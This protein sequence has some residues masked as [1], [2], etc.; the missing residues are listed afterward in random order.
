MK[1]KLLIASGI[2]VVLLGVG[3]LV[4]KQWLVGYLTPDFLVQEIEK[5]WNCRA[6]IDSVDV[7]LLGTTGIELG[8]V[9]LAPRDAFSNEG[10]LL[11]K[12]TS[13][14]E[15][16]IEILS[17]SV[18][19]EIRPME[20]IKRQLNIRDLRFTGLRVVTRINEDGDATLEPLFDKPEIVASAAKTAASASPKGSALIGNAASSA[21]T[22]ASNEAIDSPTDSAPEEDESFEAGDLA[23]STVADR[24]EIVD[25]QATILIEASG[26][27]IQL[28]DIELALTEID[29]DPD[30]L[31]SHNKA[32][33]QFGTDILV[34]PPEASD[35][36]EAYLTAHL[37]GSGRI[38]PFNPE[39]GKIDA[40]WTTDLTLHQGAEINTFPIVLQLQELLEDAGDAGVDLGDLNIRGTLLADTQTQLGHAQGKYLVKK[41]LSL[42]LPDTELIIQEGSWF[43]SGSNQHR[44]RGTMVASDGLTSQ[45]EA[46]VDVF[47]AEKAGN[48]ASEGLRSLLMS[49]LMKDDRL[50][51]EFSSKGDLSSPKVDLVTP[52]GDLSDVIGTSKDA[53]KGLEEVGKSLLDNLLGN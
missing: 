1:R 48:L 33:G 2:L 51:V 46:K 38:R 29:V 45:I 52:L 47:L 8:G 18:S 30:A 6:H 21:E 43:H 23:F 40:V 39:T 17:E 34:I 27:T 4:A 20:L 16:N 3:A 32:L 15:E 11:E 31:D 12:R 44:L 7:S 14:P 26:A 28:N 19:L 25:G 35:L 41:P 36:Q 42:P 22:P 24:I 37:S 13:I 9:S 5:R 10:T 49:P 50:T 53:L